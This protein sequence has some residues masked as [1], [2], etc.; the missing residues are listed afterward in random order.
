MEISREFIESEIQTLEQEIGKAQAF[1][2]QAQA[3]SAAYKMLLTRL[4]TPEPELQ[5]DTDADNLSSTP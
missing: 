4:D 3:V 5:K 1:L 2:T